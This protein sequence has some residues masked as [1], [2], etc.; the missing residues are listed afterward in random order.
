MLFIFEKWFEKC[1]ESRSKKKKCLKSI[2]IALS[3]KEKAKTA[4]IAFG[5]KFLST[6]LLQQQFYMVLNWIIVVLL[7]RIPEQKA[8]MQCFIECEKLS[9]AFKSHFTGFNGN[10]N[11]MNNKC[12]RFFACLLQSALSTDS[13]I[14]MAQKKKQQRRRLN[15]K[16]VYLKAPLSICNCICIEH[17]MHFKS[18][19][20]EGKKWSE[21]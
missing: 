9:F 2:F 4:Q 1:T 19:V 15:E 7:W 8:I 14:T 5:K 11:S 18:V 21:N 10:N 13:P 3:W 17:S 16:R 20:S 12:N 6:V